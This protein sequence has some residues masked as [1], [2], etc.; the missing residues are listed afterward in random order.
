MQDN[1]VRVIT[2]VVAEELNDDESAARLGDRGRVVDRVQIVR[3][4]ASI[5]SEFETALA[6][7]DILR[8]VVE[9]EADGCDAVVVDCMGDPGLLPA[10][11][12]AGMLVLGPAQVGMHI[13]SLLGHRFSVLTISEET[14]SELDNLA[15]LYGLTSRLASVRSVDIP[16]LELHEAERVAD[17]LLEQA[18][19]AVVEDRAHVLLLGCTGMEGLAEALLDGLAD[20]GITGVPVIDPMPT[21][22]RV[23]QALVDAGLSHSKRSYPYPPTKRIDGYDFLPDSPRSPVTPSSPA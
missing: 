4:P 5:E 2:P 3:G 11:E 20:R 17:A 16:V 12:L 8:L 23:A 9:A 10:R 21:A 13:A 19:L 7:P 18:T 6:V 14:V 1:R 22:V 15:A